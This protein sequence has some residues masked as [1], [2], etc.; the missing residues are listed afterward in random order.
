VHP[1][2]RNR[3]DA[4]RQLAEILKGAPLHD[5][6]VLAI[7][8]GGVLVG[9]ALADGLGAELDAVMSRKLGAPG[10]PELAL[11]AVSEDGR[12]HLDLSN[13]SATG[14]DQGYIETERRRQMAL[15][16]S[17]VKMIRAVRPRAPIAGRSVI[18]T[19]DGLATGST[20]LAA[21]DTILPA[22]PRERIVAV[23]VAAPDRI[24]AIAQRVDRF[25]SLLSPPG[26]RAVG[27]YYE[28]F[29][30][31]EDD[32][33]VEILHRHAQPRIGA[34]TVRSGRAKESAT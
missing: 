23:P 26:F 32:R 27:E 9:E 2:F 18:L 29:R 1:V 10:T 22:G 19:D 31:V 12:I 15:I 14:A 5:A 20:M 13:I 4:G 33:V 11:G 3:S 16:E 28:D 21:I 17:R 34:V 7:P 8:R 25:V 30:P 6:L 24:K